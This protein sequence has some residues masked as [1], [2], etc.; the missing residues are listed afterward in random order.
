MLVLYPSL[1]LLCVCEQRLLGSVDSAL[2]RPNQILETS[3]IVFWQTVKTQLNQDQIS[4]KD[5]YYMH[6]SA[7]LYGLRFCGT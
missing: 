1:S 5:A 2:A 3:K 6:I 7:K 4:F